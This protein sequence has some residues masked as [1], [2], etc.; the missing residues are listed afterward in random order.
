MSRIFLKKKDTYVFKLKFAFGDLQLC[1]SVTEETQT[2]AVVRI[3][4]SF[5]SKAFLLQK[6]CQQL[7]MTRGASLP[8]YQ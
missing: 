3:S 1:V 7:N 4:R 6:L 2:G 5:Q 8:Y